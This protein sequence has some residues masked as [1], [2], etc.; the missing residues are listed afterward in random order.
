MR[1]LRHLTFVGGKGPVFVGEADSAVELG[2]AGEAFLDAWHADE[3]DAE[4][5]AVVVVADLFEARGLRRSGS[6]MMSSSVRPLAQEL[7][8]M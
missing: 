5:V 8:W 2:V 7:W 4:V 3:D 1:C 6:S